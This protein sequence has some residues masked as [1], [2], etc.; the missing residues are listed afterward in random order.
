MI[1]IL[2]NLYNNKEIKLE[3]IK[4]FRNYNVI[5]ILKN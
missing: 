5:F 3:Y 4:K 2:N 1:L